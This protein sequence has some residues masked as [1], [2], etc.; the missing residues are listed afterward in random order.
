M[1]LHLTYEYQL[2]IG[3]IDHSSIIGHMK[4][5]LNTFA[6]KPQYS[7]FYIGIT[8]NLEERKLDHQRKKPG[9][10]LMCAIYRDEENIV[11]NSFHNLE[12]D[13]INAMR[14]GIRHPVNNQLLL[15]CDNGPSGSLAKNWL[16][17]LI[18]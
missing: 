14:S 8:S 13:A 1:S 6:N 18:G 5:V 12:R 17:I 10:T 3:L 7:K 15:R 9:Y 2:D 4:S 11:S 16:Y